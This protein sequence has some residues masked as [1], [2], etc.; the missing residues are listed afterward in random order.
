MVKQDGDYIGKIL[1]QRPGL[2][3]PVR[4]KVVGL[5]SESPDEPIPAGAH[6]VSTIPGAGN[7]NS[8]GHVTS[9]TWSPALK[10]YIGLGL[11]TRGR[12]RMDEFLTAADPLRGRMV[13]VRVTSPVF[14]DPAGER[15]HA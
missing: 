11:L 5:I 14:F 1:A 13:R 2:V 12:Q 6:L 4:P 9:V 15:M 7:P 8:E 10:R 3:D